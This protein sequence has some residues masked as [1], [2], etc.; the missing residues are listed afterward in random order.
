MAENVD[1]KFAKDFGKKEKVL[2]YT[3]NTY[4]LTRPTK[5]GEVMALIR[6]CQ[7]KSI[8]EWEK[9]YFDNAYTKTKEPIKITEKLLTELG[10]RLYTKITEC[11]IPEWTAA[12]KQITKQ[13][14]IDYIRELTINRTYDGFLLEKSVIH[15]NLA[16]LFPKVKF[17]ESDPEMD[18]S[19]DIDYLGWVGEHA[20]GIQIKPITANA[21]F[22]NYN[23]SERMQK[24]FEKF[25]DEYKGKVFI[26][27][28]SRENNR[29]VIRNKEVIEEI[30][31]EID[32]IREL[33]K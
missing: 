23:I 25:E 24:S 6:E 16:K 1:I 19:G 18:H 12:F 32:R 8:S 7:P 5:V 20:F 2:N 30:R 21:N 17:M 33:N 15:D 31:K 3:S 10:E 27:F 9:F 29:K 4:Q 13:D 22:G 28:S 11:V 26:V 14:C